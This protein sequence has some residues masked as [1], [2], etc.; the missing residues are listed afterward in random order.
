MDAISF[1]A[2]AGVTV[3]FV[4]LCTGGIYANNHRSKHEN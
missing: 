1:M 4:I 3:F 2:V